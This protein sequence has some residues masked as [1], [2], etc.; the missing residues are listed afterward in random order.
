M[1][2]TTVIENCHVATVDEARTEHGPGHVVVEGNLA[3]WRMDTLAHA[4]IDD[5]VAALVLGSPPPL[6]LL[7]VDGRPVVEDG[8]GVTVDE[9]ALACDAA[10]VHQSLLSKVR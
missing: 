2:S 4:D 6:K 1:N 8:H 7:L 9:E 3:L 10:S 5:P